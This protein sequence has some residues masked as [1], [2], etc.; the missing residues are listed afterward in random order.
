MPPFD[1][2]LLPATEQEIARF[3]GN[4]GIMIF[5]SIDV[6]ATSTWSAGQLNLAAT[7]MLDESEFTIA[8]ELYGPGGSMDLTWRLQRLGTNPEYMVI[9]ATAPANVQVT[10][11]IVTSAP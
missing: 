3:K 2:R 10:G 6:T 4:Q 8:A 7:E 5:K 11:R 9:Y 1:V